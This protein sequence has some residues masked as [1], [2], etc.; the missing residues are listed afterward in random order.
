MSLKDYKA[1]ID[2]CAPS[3]FQVA[4]GGHGDPNK[5]EL[6]GEIL[7]Y[8]RSKN[9]IPNYTTS[10][11]NLTE[12][13]INLTKKFCGAVAVSHQRAK[14]TGEAIRSFIEAGVKTNIHYVLGE[15]TIDEAIDRL[16][17][18]NWPEGIN[19]IVFLLYKP[20][21]LG[22]EDRIL[23]NKEKTS[24]LFS[25]IDDHSGSY[26]IG[27]DSCSMPMLIQN[28]H[29]INLNSVDT[30]EGARYSMY[31][32]ADML[33]LPCSFDQEYKWAFNLKNH[34]IEE[35]WNSPQFN[36]FRNHFVNSCPSCPNRFM[37]LGGCPIKNNIVICEMQERKTHARINH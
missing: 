24:K 5:H 9:I 13:E 33:A 17:T 23:R 16:Q 36:E 12:E 25:I 29:K 30:C 32:T 14:H 34:T 27:F 6:F 37:C 2:E 4:L 26:K 10:G 15:H 7:K 35:T 8:T 22:R 19:A 1:I 31:V 20:V 11:I 28:A 18:N 21:G 3:L